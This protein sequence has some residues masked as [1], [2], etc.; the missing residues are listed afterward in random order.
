MLTDEEHKRLLEMW[1][2]Q[3]VKLRRKIAEIARPAVLRLPPFDSLQE[4]SCLDPYK[5]YL[6]QRP[7]QERT[8]LIDAFIK[9]M[10]F[11]VGGE[12]C[13]DRHAMELWSE[14][15]DEYQRNH[16]RNYVPP[17]KKQ[18]SELSNGDARKIIVAQFMQLW[19]EF[20]RGKSRDRNVLR[21][22]KP[23]A[24]VDGI[25]FEF[26]FGTFGP[27]HFTP[28]IGTIRDEFAVELSAIMCI[29]KRTWEFHDAGAC[30]EAV[31]DV[32]RLGKILM[33]LLDAKIS[34]FAE[35]M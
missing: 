33:P 9:F 29:R 13:R 35:E 5:K 8:L 6:D 10:E 7:P 22:V 16:A 4:E 25:K 3:E 14:I 20:G 23:N 27:G 15:G 21:L 28:Y 2:T 32:I 31:A 17:P 19:P 26:D 24:H 11:I 12:V 18:M 1:G 34:S 30:V